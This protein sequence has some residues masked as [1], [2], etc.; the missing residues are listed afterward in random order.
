MTSSKIILLTLAV[1]AC[2]LLVESRSLAK[3]SEEI[4]MKIERINEQL[5]GVQAKLRD[6]ASGKQLADT[7]VRKAQRNYP[8]YFVPS[9]VNGK[10]GKSIQA[11]T[12][13]EFE[14]KYSN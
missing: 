13:G 8:V 3:D 9:K 5:P 2:V 10:F 12:I 14:S 11:F 4:M 7:P 1:L 6:A